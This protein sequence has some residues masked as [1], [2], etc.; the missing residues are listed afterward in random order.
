MTANEQYAFNKGNEKPRMIPRAKPS[1]DKAYSAKQ[2]AK[3]NDD[4]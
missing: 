3:D 1:T 2:I 4:L